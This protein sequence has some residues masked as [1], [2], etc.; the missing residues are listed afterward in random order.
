MKCVIP[1]F[2]VFCPAR[3]SIVCTFC[4]HMYILY[5]IRSARKHAQGTHKNNRI[6]GLK[7]LFSAFVVHACMHTQAAAQ[8]RDARVRS[9]AVVVRLL[10]AFLC[11]CIYMYIHCMDLNSRWTCMGFMFA[12]N[13]NADAWIF[14]HSYAKPTERERAT[15][16]AQCHCCCRCFCCRSGD[17][18]WRVPTAH[19][20]LSTYKCRHTHTSEAR[21]L[22]DTAIST[23]CA[24]QIAGHSF[25]HTEKAANRRKPS[26]GGA[27]ISLYLSALVHF[28]C[29][30]PNIRSVY[31]LHGDWT[32]VGLSMRLASSFRRKGF[33][34]NSLVDCLVYALSL[35]LSA[36]ISLF[37]M[38]LRTLCVH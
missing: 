23:V 19:T 38:C 1:G 6:N 30:V 37:Y 36:H 18:F 15:A 25:L 34:T 12:K 8:E 9:L 7:K 28:I 20:C 31:I 3:A 16:R 17:M 4:T 29:V 2:G 5:R 24:V 14:L 21:A 27:R 10:C 33:V 26:G 35:S 22:C 32:G 11:S 13:P